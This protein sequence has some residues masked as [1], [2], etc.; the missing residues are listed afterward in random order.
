MNDNSQKFPRRGYVAR[1]CCED[2]EAE[3]LKN[4]PYP[5][6]FF[7]DDYLNRAIGIFCSFL[8]CQTERNEENLCVTSGA[9]VLSL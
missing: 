3:I 8:T 7:T 1:I 5:T 4:I 2:V 9:G 6:R